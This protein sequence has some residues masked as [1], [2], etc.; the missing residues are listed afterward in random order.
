M[1][2]GAS[3]AAPGRRLGFRGGQ[4]IR[5]PVVISIGNVVSVKDGVRYFEE[6]VADSRVDYYAGRGEAPGVWR[7]EAAEDLGLRG[8]VGREDLVRVLEGRDPR[9]GEEFGTHYG[10]RKNVAFDVTFSLPKSVSLLYVLGNEEV[11]EAVIRAMDAGATAAHDYLQRHAG[12]GRVYDRVQ[13]RLERVRARFVT[14]SFVHRTARPV[15]RDGV[16]TIDPQLHTHLLVSSFARRD[17]GTWGQLY[18]EPLYAHAAAAGAIGQAATRDALVRDLGVRVRT[19]PNG[20][21]EL[22]GF[23]AEQLADFSH[24]H[25][26]ALAAAA[27]AGTSSLSG[28]KVA[29][30]DTRESKHE[31]EPDADLFAHWNRR[32]AAVGLDTE[33][34]GDLLGLEQVRELRWFGVGTVQEVV[35]RGEGGLT[36]QASVF[37]RRDLVRS[38]ASHAP[39]GMRPEAIEGL[40]DAILAESKTA[41]FL[42]VDPDVATSMEPYGYAIGDPVNSDDPTGDAPTSRGCSAYGAAL[43][44]TD[45]NGFHLYG[46]SA[47]LEYSVNVQCF[48]RSRFTGTFNLNI[49]GPQV[50]FQG[51]SGLLLFP[52]VGHGRPGSRG[53]RRRGYC[54]GMSFPLFGARKLRG[55][56][57]PIACS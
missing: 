3:A 44:S 52:W 50:N 19:S 14:A 37:T 2:Q 27:A 35:G 23:T 8:R 7:G 26:Q 38:L 56:A 47:D 31:V 54:V 25:R 40:A 36:S 46:T 51:N 28:T 57:A 48:G 5:E 34:V 42:T 39:L 49:W 17:G 30:L 1:S 15:T 13:H 41:D 29:V 53:E 21:F 33:G 9:T 6:A 11:R 55:P 4:R 18:S 32:A 10:T 16:T 12:W 43:R 22:E 20:T 45:G 24:R